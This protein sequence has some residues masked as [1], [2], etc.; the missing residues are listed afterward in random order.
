MNPKPLTLLFLEGSIFSTKNYLGSGVFRNPVFMARE[1]LHVRV[2]WHCH[3]APRRK[4]RWPFVW[5]SCLL[6][7]VCEYIK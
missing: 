5:V 2:Q 4:V 3:V 6:T 7:P 1:G